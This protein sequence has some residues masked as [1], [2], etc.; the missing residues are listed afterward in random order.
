MPLQE[1]WS[2][3]LI[4]EFKEFAIKGNMID[5]AVGLIVGAAFGKV[6]SSLVENVLM[7]PIGL[8]VGNMD[9]SDLAVTL[10]DATS[11]TDAVQLKLGLFL[12]TLIDFVI[13]SFAI[14]MVIKQINRL[15][16]AP[17]PPEAPSSR[18]CPRCLS[19]ISRKATRCGH[20]TSDVQP[21]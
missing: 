7:P 11:T 9:F 21:A 1:E 13:V 2:M 17:P 15:K 5:M 6:V 16:K 14:F 19:L 20:C 8:L 3:G 12:N 18:E 10:K 4:S